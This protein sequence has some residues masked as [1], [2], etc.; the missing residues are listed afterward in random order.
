[1]AYVFTFSRINILQ[2]VNAPNIMHFMY[3]E[4][5]TVMNYVHSTV[6]NQISKYL[7]LLS[8]RKS[9]F[10][11]YQSRQNKTICFLLFF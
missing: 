6:I 7:I 4:W 11:K 8:I 3:Y 5:M 2:S 10:P 9:T 1:M